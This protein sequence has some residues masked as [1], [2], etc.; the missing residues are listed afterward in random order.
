MEVI[1]ITVIKKS[2]R[3]DIT[4]IVEAITAAETTIGTTTQTTLTV[5]QTA[6]L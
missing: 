4:I 6:E 3:E 5:I 1:Y 2:N